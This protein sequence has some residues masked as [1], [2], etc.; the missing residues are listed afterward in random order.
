MRWLLILIL[1]FLNEFVNAEPRYALLIANQ[2][3]PKVEQDVNIFGKLETA[4]NEMQ[5]LAKVL[6]SYGF[7]VTEVA[8]ADSETM[9]KAINQFISSLQAGDVGLLYYAGHGVQVDMQ[10]YLIPVNKKFADAIDV[11]HGAYLAQSAIEKL[12]RSNAQVKLVFLDSCRN[13]LPVKDKSR[14]FNER[15]FAKMDAKGVVISYATGL[16]EIANDE[17]TYTS[18]LIK[19]IQAHANQPI[20]VVLSEAQELTA[21]A[22][23]DR[24]TPWYEK[25]MV[26]KFCFGTCGRKS[27]SDDELERLREE[28]ERLRQQSTNA[29]QPVMIEPSSLELMEVK[30]DPK[31]PVYQGGVKGVA[32]N[33]SS[34]GSDSLNNSM[35]LWTEA[36][37]KHYPS[38]QIQVQGAGSSTAPPALTEGTANFGPMIRSMKEGELQAFEQKRGYAPTEIKVAIDALAVFVNKDN[39]VAAAGKGLTMQEVDSIFSSTRKCGGTKDLTTWEQLEVK[40][41]LA[42]QKIQ[43]FGRNPVSGTYGYFREHVLCKG[44]FKHTV[45]EQPGA[46]SVVQ[47][48]VSSLNAI[49]YSGIGYVTAG[50]K[51]VPLAN[52]KGEAF[53]PATE[54]S[55]L[56]GKYPLSRFLYIYV[57]KSPNRP[58]PLLEQ[59]FLK[60]VLSTEGQEIVVKDGYIPLPAKLIAKELSKFLSEKEVAEITKAK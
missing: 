51:V 42:K 5:G 29:G 52:K 59:E 50:V 1:L 3:Y 18:Q 19:A 14:G 28:N 46:A 47:S 21:Q 12:S 27:A 33:L 56:S 43:L 8:D 22:T 9:S 15:G 11:K 38:V 37:K 31:L 13:H 6:R 45:N 48:V 53:V 24:Q 35:T 10:N 57:N 32:G 26:G 36:F 30:L 39:A 23:G 58:L 54:E 44:D 55:V 34:V 4:V 60:M 16:G 17:I 20:E 49:G 7:N 25:G 41:D 2:N 40:G